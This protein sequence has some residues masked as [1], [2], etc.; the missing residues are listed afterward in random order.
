[1][2]DFTYR[3]GT[4]CSEQVSLASVAE[5][6]GTPL[7]V[8]S[9]GTLVD[10]FRR[11]AKAFQALSPL[12]CFSAKALSNVHL[13][14]V[15]AQEGAGIDVVSG[16]E[17][18]RA[19]VAGVDPERV[20]FAG[21]GKSADE[22]RLAVRSD[23]RCINV[24]SEAEVDLLAAIAREEG[25][26]PRL[27]IRVNPDVAPDQRTP[28]KTTT[29]T[30]GG[31]FGIDID[32]AGALFERICGDGSLRVEGFHL[33]LGSPIFDPQ[34]YAVALDRLLA[35]V[36]ELET[37]GRRVTT[38]NVGGGFAAEY[39]SHT[40]PSWDD[41]ATEI[42][43]RLAG[44]AAGGG[45]VILEP[46]RTIAANAGILLTTVRYLKQA[47][48]RQVAIV[49]AGMTHLVRAAMYDSYHFIWPVTPEAGA[50]PRARG[51]QREDDGLVAYDV[52]GPICETS[53]YLAKGRALPALHSGEV[54]AVFSA[55]AYGMTMASNYNGQPRPAEALVDGD[56]A[57]LIRRR[58]SYQDLVALEL[59][60][61]AGPGTPQ[62]AG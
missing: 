14:R 28:A 59:F 44:F 53:D 11:F 55:G 48:D 34:V 46:G 62:S 10:H 22:L 42:V 23:I 15:L 9:R 45:Q 35:V 29:G 60:G 36:T 21:V 57:T 27:A 1:M 61:D 31:K 20:V 6:Y 25:R 47:G 30:R 39:T 37:A 38:M 33:H 3:D 40:A 16:G 56:Q 2:D 41:F 4:L 7:Y 17:L 5:R 54:L 50:L 12:I 13:L 26:R 32:R 49:D 52:A 43:A 18:H 8:Y 51:G 24:E 19:M 58:E